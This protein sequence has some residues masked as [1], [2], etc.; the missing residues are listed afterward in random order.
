MPA[1]LSRRPWLSAGKLARGRST[2]VGT[3]L[4]KR[5]ARSHPASR[6]PNG[7]GANNHPSAS[8]RRPHSGKPA[9]RRNSK[10]GLGIQ[11]RQK[12]IL[13]CGHF[14]TVQGGE[15]GQ[16]VLQRPGRK[17][18]LLG[19]RH[20]AGQVAG[21]TCRRPACPPPRLLRNNTQQGRHAGGDD[22]YKVAWC[23]WGPW[24]TWHALLEGGGGWHTIHSGRGSQKTGKQDGSLAVDYNQKN[25]IR[26]NNGVGIRRKGPL[27]R[28][29]ETSKDVGGH[30]FRLILTNREA[31]KRRRD[32]PSSA[33][34]L[35]RPSEVQ[36]GGGR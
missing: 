30:I 23:P 18:H 4:S 19:L 20:Q 28:C 16:G 36:A 26:G 22:M 27:I 8:P 3:C 25:A 6:I 33:G 5:W 2:S 35:T 31:S 9:P 32:G 1:P 13:C 7:G 11:F 12:T 24:S 10:A 29:T 15:G 34:R 17:A 14:A 21:H